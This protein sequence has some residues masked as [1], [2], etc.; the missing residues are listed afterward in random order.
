MRENYGVM[1][2]EEAIKNKKDKMKNEEK[3]KKR[4]SDGKKKWPSDTWCLFRK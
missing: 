1:T 2:K 3:E 4:D